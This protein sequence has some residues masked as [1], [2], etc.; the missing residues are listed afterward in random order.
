MIVLSTGGPVNGFTLDP[1]I[2]QIWQYTDTSDN[3]GLFCS[4]LESL[5]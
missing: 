5:F 1:V 2:L 3:G 4:P